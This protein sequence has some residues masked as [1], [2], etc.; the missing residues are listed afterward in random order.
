MSL[1]HKKIYHQNINSNLI[2]NKVDLFRKTENVMK[3]NSKLRYT[4][5]VVKQKN[6]L[7]ANSNC[8]VKGLITCLIGYYL[9]RWK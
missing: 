6:N 7:E 3:I 8:K 5:V 2:D 4:R 9:I 1:Y